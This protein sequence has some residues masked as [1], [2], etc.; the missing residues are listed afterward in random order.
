MQ[1]A[2]QGMTTVTKIPNPLIRWTVRGIWAIGMF[3]TLAMFVAGLNTYVTRLPQGTLGLDAIINA[4]EVRLDPAPDS[5]AAQAGARVGDVLLSINSQPVTEN[6][7]PGDFA[8]RYGEIVEIVVRGTDGDTRTLNIPVSIPRIDEVTLLMRDYDLPHT[9]SMAL[10]FGFEL[11]TVACFALLAGLVAW[12]R[13]DSLMGLL[14][15]GLMLSAGVRFSGFFAVLNN[16][17]G[18]DVNRDLYLYYVIPMAVGLITFFLLFPDGRLRRRWHAGIILA[19]VLFE[20][21][22][23]STPTVDFLIY[24]IALL[25]F[26]GVVLWV[27]AQRY[28]ADF[29][30]QQ[31]QQ[32]KWV[33]LGLSLT[34]AG[35]FIPLLIRGLVWRMFQVDLSF[36]YLIQRSALIIMPITFAFAFLRYR[37][38]D[39]D[40]I[41]NRSMVYGGLTLLLALVFGAVV[42][43]VTLVAQDQQM[44]AVVIAAAAS[45]ALFNPVRQRLQ[46]LVDRRFFR[47]R[48]DLNQLQARETAFE[49]QPQQTGV[50][51]GK[52]IGAYTVGELI[53]RGGMGEVYRGQHPTLARAVAVK[54]LPPEPAQKADSRVRF[55]REAQTVAALRHPNIVHLYDFGVIDSTSYMVM[56][57]VAGVDLSTHLRE[58]GILQLEE[59]LPLL[60]DL[61]AALDYAHSQ[62]IV[63]RDVKPSNIMLLPITGSEQPYRAILTDFGIARIT[64]ANSSQLTQTGMMGTIDYAAPEQILSAKTV[65]GR[66]DQYALGVI[67]Y[68]AL[69]GELP[70][71]GSAA[72]ILFAHLQQPAPDAQAINAAIPASVAQ[73]IRRAMSKDPASRYDAVQVFVAA[74]GSATINIGT[75]G[76]KS[77]DAF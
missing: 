8:W 37:L 6:T 56:E 67:A 70:F 33:I 3:V 52:Q 71:K 17:S 39:I 24:T 59:L 4:G 60:N 13:S 64:S 54:I 40:L 21:F 74:L 73:A 61:A 69:T 49:T 22:Y 34:L 47:L 72:Q 46:R 62:Q 45:G 27:L 58:R 55:E 76:G 11:F 7:R 15:S 12:R 19:Y 16:S 18:W 77:P 31:R 36:L 30:S 50:W 28:R 32:T 26:Y 35:M 38:Y 63:H 2:Q 44:I 25:T 53:G 42:F 20:V 66:A 68:Q 41:V 14:M 75:E 9:V 51:T 5:M 23:G 1:A 57:Y 65:D 48:L 29:T 43:L 10:A